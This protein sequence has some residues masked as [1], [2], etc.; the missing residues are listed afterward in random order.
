VVPRPSYGLIVEGDYDVAVYGTLICK[1]APDVGTVIPRPVGGVTKLPR[2]LPALL[3]DLEFVVSGRPVDKVMVIRDTNGKSATALEE[4]LAQ[5]IHGQAFAFPRG[6]QFHATRRTAETWLLADPA[7]VNTVA[8]ARR[9]RQVSEVHGE[10]EEIEDPKGK[11]RS[12]LR[13]AQLPYDPAV[14][15]ELAGEIQLDRLRYRCA[16]F[17]AFEKK[18]LDC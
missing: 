6:I 16:S 12:L 13:E 10:L 5:R 14:C 15:R 17:R 4:Q 11:L 9:G 1:I 18:V 3:R 7:A 2:L 8:K